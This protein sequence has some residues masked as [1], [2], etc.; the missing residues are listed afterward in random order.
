MSITNPAPAATA[1]GRPFMRL[2]ETLGHAAA[3]IGNTGA[4]GVYAQRLRHLR[5]GYA[6]VSRE[7]GEDRGSPEAAVQVH[8]LSTW[9]VDVGRSSSDLSQTRTPRPRASPRSRA[10]PRSRRPAQSSRPPR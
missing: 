9:I 8:R 1:T 10:R 5:H 7:G 4:P 2:D 3:A 6:V